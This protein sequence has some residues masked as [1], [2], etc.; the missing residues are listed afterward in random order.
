MDAFERA[1]ATFPANRWVD[2]HFEDI[3]AS[4]R[5]EFE[6]LLKFVGLDWTSRF[7]AGFARYRFRPERSKAFRHELSPANLA[8]LE[9]VLG[10]HLRIHGYEPG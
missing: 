7:E 9:G 3:L 2:V 6:A 8:R 5:A 4:P 10:G 1:R